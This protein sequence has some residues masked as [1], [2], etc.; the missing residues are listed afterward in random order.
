MSTPGV[1]EVVLELYIF[2]FSN[3]LR[4]S[5]YVLL[6]SFAQVLQQLVQ[7]N[8]NPALGVIIFLSPSEFTSIS[9]YAHFEFN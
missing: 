8:P 6:F 1:F 9:F 2:N 5:V 4:Q 7:E 3:W